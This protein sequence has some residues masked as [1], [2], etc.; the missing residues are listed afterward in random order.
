MYSCDF[1]P[2]LSMCRARLHRIR[3]LP[4]YLSSA[5]VRRTSPPDRGPAVFAAP[6]LPVVQGRLDDEAQLLRVLKFATVARKGPRRAL[7]RVSRGIVEKI[8]DS[9]QNTGPRMPGQTGV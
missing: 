7:V 9:T 2:V 4:Q 8:A 3:A 6:V 5:A 1:L